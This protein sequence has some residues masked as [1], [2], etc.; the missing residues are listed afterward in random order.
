MTTS[1]SPAPQDPV[2]VPCAERAELLEGDAPLTLEE[3]NEELQTQL[4]EVEMIQE[5]LSRSEASLA[6][7]Q[8]I[9]HIGNWDWNVVTQGRRG[10]QA[11]KRQL[12]GLADLGA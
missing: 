9:A 10:Q 5:A 8:R 7:A 11:G 3:L 4:A 1:R 2:Q 6:N 12:A